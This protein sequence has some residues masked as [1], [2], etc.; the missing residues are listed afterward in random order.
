MAITIYIPKDWKYGIAE[1]AT[2]GT[3][4]LDAA[5]FME[6]NVDTPE[7]DPDITFVDTKAAH[8][9]RNPTNSE[10]I[11]RTSGASPK[12]SLSG[13]AKKNEVDVFLYTMFQGVSEAAA[14][15]FAKT[16]TF[17]KTSQPDFSVSAG[18]FLTFIAFDPITAKSVKVKD[19]ISQDITFSCSPNEYLKF[20]ASM[21]GRGLP[22]H[23]STPSGTWTVA[24]SSLFHYAEISAAGFGSSYA[25]PMNLSG[26]FE[27]K[28]SQTVVPVG[29]LAGQFQTFGL[30][31]RA[32]TFKV[33]MMHGTATNTL[34]SNMEAQTNTLM[35]IRWGSAN[36]GTTD[37]DLDFS[38]NALIKN[39]KMI[40]SDGDITSIE[41]TGDIV[42]PVSTT[43][44]I[45]VIC[46]NAIDRSW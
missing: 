23:A 18:E 46:A 26:P 6:L 27:I 15:P 10:T 2:W 3:A 31:D 24:S 16:F 22:T 1:Q 45:T 7:L 30:V 43:N 25:T 33:T 35:R 40:N 28:L 36:P 39:I 20:A 14:T 5:A 4:G 29:S 41:V 9:T 11:V 42:A 34:R 38:W 37:G 44:P 21:I 8:K 19:L 32:F 12:L 13:L 17:N